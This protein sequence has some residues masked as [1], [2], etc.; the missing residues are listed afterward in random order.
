M[1]V[2]RRSP[3]RSR[4]SP[5][6]LG[7]VHRRHL[8]AGRPGPW[9]TARYVLLEGAQGTMLDV[10]HGTYPFVTSSN[11]IAG[12][13]CAGIGI[14]PTRISRVVGVSK[15]Y[16]TRVGEG[17]V[18]DRARRRR[19]GRSCSERW[20][21][22]RDDDRPP[23]PLRLDRPRRPAL[24]RTVVGVHRTRADQARCAVGIR[25]RAHLRGLPDARRRAAD[26]VPVPPDRVPRL[27]TGVPGPGRLGGRTSR[28]AGSSSICRS[29]R[30]ITSTRSRLP[31][32]CRSHSYGTGQ[33]RHQVID[34]VEF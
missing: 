31:S 4:R 9:R 29:P 28:S 18:P 21:R 10:D 1:D 2:P 12:A 6:R 17:P 30:A 14:G 15:A 34:T 5:P 11:P 22:V 23:A 3:T 26:R 19:R 33:G 32:R 7:A 20:Q 16:T 13:A 25:A 8:P 27:H 24:C